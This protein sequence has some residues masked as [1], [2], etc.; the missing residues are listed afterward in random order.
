VAILWRTIRPK[1]EKN[2]KGAHMKVPFLDLPL[3]HKLLRDEL[4]RVFEDALATASFIGGPQVEAFEEEFARFCQTEYCVGVGSGTDALR[5]ALMAAGIGPG[6]E[7][8]TVPFTFVATVEAIIQVGAKPTFVDVD[9]RTC[10]MDPDKLED[11]LAK[12]MRRG[13]RKP[14]PKAIIPVHL[15]GHP[16]PMDQLL[17]IAQRYGLS[18]IEDACQA[19]GALY[20]SK[21]SSSTSH[22]GSWVPCGSMGLAGAFSF[23]PGK[24]LGACGEAGAV[25]TRD[26]QLAEKVR[27]IRDHGQ[28]KKYYH[29][30]EGYN[31]R[32]DAIQAG[33]LRVKLKHLRKWNEARRQKAATYGELLSGIEGL[34]LPSEAPYARAV[35]H[36]YVVRTPYRDELAQ[37]LASQHI[38]FGLHYPLP[39]H[40]QRAYEKLGYKRGDFPV[41]EKLASEV[42]SLPLFPEITQEQQEAVAR[43]LMG[44]R[45][46]SS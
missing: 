10:T 29:Q 25:T 16:C 35:Y 42:L 26:P 24:N 39:V 15:Y 31:G 18:V 46:K 7:V 22:D 17:E 11:Y 14:I 34:T 1:P 23:Y 6:D 37:H 4:I 36:L 32:L 3:Q 30:V 27:M 2:A 41:S 40:L 5:F 43:A 28:A 44:F 12:R 38:G 33:I 45:V 8:I 21:S 19:H 20:F 13:P 9:E